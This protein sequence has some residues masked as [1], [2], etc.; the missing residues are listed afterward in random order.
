M[1]YTQ[2][3]Q[4]QQQTE[5]VS[6]RGSKSAGATS[7]YFFIIENSIFC[8]I[9]ESLNGIENSLKSPPISPMDQQNR[10]SQIRKSQPTRSA[11]TGK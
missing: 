6:A 7:N 10:L 8:F 11:S 1:A 4:Q 9:I 5:H 2:Q 3:Q